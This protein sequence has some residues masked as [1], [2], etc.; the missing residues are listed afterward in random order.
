M[1]IF[2][3]VLA[4]VAAFM[5]SAMMLVQKQYQKNFGE[6]LASGFR[7]NVGVGTVAM[8]I[9][10]VVCGFRIGFEP[11][12][13]IMAMTSSLA[14]MLYTVL[15]FKLMQSGQ[16]AV[17]SIFLMSG[18]MTVPYIFGLIFLGEAKAFKPLSL[19]GLILILI[20]CVLSSG[21]AKTEKKYIPLCICVFFLNGITSIVSKVH[22]VAGKAENA[23]MSYLCAQ[24]ADIET[25]SSESFVFWC[26][27]S[28]VVIGLLALGAI[29]V[30]AKK[31]KDRAESAAKN[32]ITVKTALLFLMLAVVASAIDGA[33]YFMQL[34]VAENV[35]AT[36]QYPLIT[37]GSIIFTALLA[38]A[39]LREK[40]SRKIV[41]SL[42]LCLIGC[43]MFI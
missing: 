33:S 9:F 24:L 34:V 40:P 13:L 25:V 14:V 35:P 4:L 43:C 1:N 19:V 38:W 37:G 20:A 7:F 2:Y 10:A 31:G 11:F 17:Y 21:N 6:T 29:A 23:D 26:G 12:S 39:V 42:V 18:G 22:Q 15:G 36:L 32:G 16:V 8:L 27:F 5:I 41:A 28:R 3:Y 30:F